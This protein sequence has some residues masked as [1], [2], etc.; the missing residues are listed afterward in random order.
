[1]KKQPCWITRDKKIHLDKAS[2]DRHAE[3]AFGAALCKLAWEMV[4]DDG[5]RKPTKYHRMLDR[6][7]ALALSKTFDELIA[8]RD[9]RTTTEE[10]DD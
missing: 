7:H 1:M 3:E 9:D 2:A 6:L 4:A 5:T 8:L 10:D